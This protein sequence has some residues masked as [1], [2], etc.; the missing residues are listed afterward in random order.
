M[1]IN[2]NVFFIHIPRTGGRYL[3][4]LLYNNFNCKEKIIHDKI[5]PHWHYPIYLKIDNELNGNPKFFTVLRDPFEKI[6]SQLK[7]EIKRDKN[8]LDK[9]KDR[10]YFFDYIEWQRSVNSYENNWYR[11][12]CDFVTNNTY[13]WHHSL[14]FEQYFFN[15]LSDHLKLHIVNKQKPA[16]ESLTEGADD[17]VDYSD[18]DLSA[19]KKNTYIYYEKDIILSDKVLN[20]LKVKFL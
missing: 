5:Y 13:I 18:I 2:D 9:L 10:N 16:Y 19:I 20:D 12:Q 8:I 17:P 3:K 7:I 6:L 1:I 15:W 4:Q 14:G 11:P